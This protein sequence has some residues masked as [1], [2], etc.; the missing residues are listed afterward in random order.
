M[1][2][3]VLLVLVGVVIGWVVPEPAFVKALLSKFTGK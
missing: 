2:G 1:L 3:T